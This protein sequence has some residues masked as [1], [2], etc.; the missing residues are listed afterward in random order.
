MPDRAAFPGAEQARKR[1][2]HKVVDV[3]RRHKSAQVG[4]ERRLM[5]REF[6]RKPRCMVG[7]G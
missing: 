3:G 1:L 4:A 5:G 7:R 6:G 2:L